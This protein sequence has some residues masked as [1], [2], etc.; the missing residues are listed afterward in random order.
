MDKV[1]LHPW[2]KAGVIDQ[3]VLYPT[4]VGTPQG[5]P[6]SPTVMHRTLAGIDTLVREHYPSHTRRGR[7]AQ[8]HIVPYADAVISTGS[9][10][11]LLAKE[12]TPLVATFLQ[13]RGLELSPEKTRI[14]PIENGVDFLGHNVRKDKGK[15][16]IKPAPKSVQALL[17]KVRGVIKTHQQ[18]ATSPRIGQLNPIIKGWANYQ[19]HVV[20]KR[21]FSQVDRAIFEPLGPWA[22]RRHPTKAKQWGAKKYVLHPGTGKW[23]FFGQDMGKDGH[24][25]TIHLTKASTGPIRRHSKIQGDANP[26]EPRWGMYFE[27]RLGVEMHQPLHGQ[28]RVWSLWQAQHGQCP[29]CHQSITA[30]TGWH[31]HHLVPRTKGGGDNLSHL[32]RLHPTCHTQGHCAGLNV[33]KP[34]PAK[35]VC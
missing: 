12:I 15:L 8:V 7:K 19:R 25:H 5:G 30:M 34:R 18:A 26:Y 4:E 13:Q 10:P 33:V 22:T 32:I 21:V 2:L 35:G 3:H 17:D 24:G 20:S 27:Q 6:I 16:L 14:T 31:V 9:A 1:M 23:M 28:R 29:V 11:E